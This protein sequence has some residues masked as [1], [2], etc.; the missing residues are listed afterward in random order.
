MNRRSH[1]EARDCRIKP[2]GAWIPLDILQ[3]P[4]LVAGV[5]V[6]VLMCHRSVCQVPK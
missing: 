6:L 3:M 2:L 5:W 1:E 4:V